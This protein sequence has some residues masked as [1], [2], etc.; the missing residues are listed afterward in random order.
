MLT[1][2]AWLSFL[3]WVRSALTWHQGV[4]GEKW[5]GPTMAPS[6]ISMDIYVSTS[7]A[8]ITAEEWLLVAG[9]GTGPIITHEEDKTKRINYSCILWRRYKL[10]PLK[11]RRLEGRVI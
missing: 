7:L 10:I 4:N 3:G 9:V 6:L 8:W 5:N 1:L 11:K 2:R